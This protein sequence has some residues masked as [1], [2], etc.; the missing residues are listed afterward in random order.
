MMKTMEG[1]AAKNLELQLEETSRPQEVS[2]LGKGLS[3]KATGITSPVERSLLRIPVGVSRRCR[4]QRW[5]NSVSGQAPWGKCT[6]CQNVVCL[7]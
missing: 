5:P 2:M 1:G 7:T 6:C 4:T 3:D